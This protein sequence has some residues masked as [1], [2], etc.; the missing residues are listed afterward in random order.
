M[1]LILFPSPQRLFAST[2]LSMNP[3]TLHTILHSTANNNYS[4]TTLV[5]HFKNSPST[6]NL[7]NKIQEF[8]ASRVD[9]TRKFQ[10][11]QQQQE[12]KKK[13]KRRPFIIDNE[14]S[15]ALA[16]SCV[17]KLPFN[18]QQHQPQNTQ[19][20][21]KESSSLGPTFIY[22]HK[23]NDDHG[24]AEVH[25]VPFIIFLSVPRILPWRC[26]VWSRIPPNNAMHLQQDK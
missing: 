16:S 14:S 15:W 8:S 21:L 24:G 13:K 19:W 23:S 7:A 10:Q 1:H 5:H 6:Q 18:K 22:T 25:Y 4:T 26:M 20:T 12:Q 17:Y 11:Q 3:L 9:F 2:F